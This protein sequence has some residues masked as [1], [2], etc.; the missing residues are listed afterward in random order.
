MIRLIV[1]ALLFLVPTKLIAGP[2]EEA[3][4]AS[5]YGGASSGG[6]TLWT[7][8]E[9]G[10][11]LTGWYDAL[12]AN[13]VT[14]SFGGLTTV[15]EDKSG[16]GYDVSQGSVDLQPEYYP[17]M[18]GIPPEPNSY[19]DLNPSLGM[20]WFNQRSAGSTNNIDLLSKTGFPHPLG[21]G[22]TPLD[23]ITIAGFFD[24]YSLGSIASF[25]AIVLDSGAPGN[26]VSISPYFNQ[27]YLFK[28][29]PNSQNNPLGTLLPGPEILVARQR[30]T[31]GSQTWQNGSI[32]GASASSTASPLVT[33]TAFQF[34]GAV[35]NGF[36]TGI[37]EVIIVSRYVD[38]IERQQIEG[39]LAHRWGYFSELPPSHPYKNDPPWVVAPPAQPTELFLYPAGFGTSAFLPGNYGYFSYYRTRPDGSRT[40]RS[41]T[42]NWYLYYSACNGKW[43]VNQTFDD[44]EGG[45]PCVPLGA[46]SYTADVSTGPFEVPLGSWA[47]QP[48]S[49]PPIP[50]ILEEF[51]DKH[52][53]ISLIS[54]DP[55]VEADPVLTYHVRSHGDGCRPVWTNANYSIVLGNEEGVTGAQSIGLYTYNGANACKLGASITVGGAGSLFD[56]SWFARTTLEGF[57]GTSPNIWALPGILASTMY[58]SYN[59]PGTWSPSVTGTWYVAGVDTAPGSGGRYYWGLNDPSGP[60]DYLYHDFGDWIIGTALHGNPGTI[61]FE[62]TSNDEVLD[63]NT[64]TWVPRGP[65]TTGTFANG[66][67][68]LV[69][70]A[71]ASTALW[72][73]GFNPGITEHGTVYFYPAGSN[74][75]YPAYE[76]DWTSPFYGKLYLYY[77][78][79]YGGMVISD[80]G[81]G[82]HPSVMY[83]AGGQTALGTNPVDDYRGAVYGLTI[84]AEDAAVDLVAVEE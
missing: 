65:N 2:S 36:K 52:R 3:F 78:S 5:Y 15:W 46:D 66:S 14:P 62:F 43:V 44:D 61:D 70:A 74:E 1:V 71:Y 38:V 10:A 83:W 9:L 79:S 11:D 39:Y 27:R 29:G 37:G 25:Y 64:V 23:G 57:P 22:V 81:I 41:D 19:L 53:Y 63:A 28:V 68:A 31:T 6:P 59:T 50:C 30:P 56:D 84:G 60:T 69:G 67:C 8:A 4:F 7:P 72:D 12:D 21:D 42:G 17:P 77:S 58:C 18:F 47:A 73:D 13:T 26:T 55:V 24:H 33:G 32:S 35:Y 40:Y 48:L 80:Q 49:G 34:G 76:S 75:G 51:S 45:I 82:A 20:V 16:Y 54:T